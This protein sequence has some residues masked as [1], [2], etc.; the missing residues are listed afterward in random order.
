MVSQGDLYFVEDVTMLGGVLTTKS[1]EVLTPLPTPT[2]TPQLMLFPTEP[3]VEP[4]AIPTP[5]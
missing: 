3:E 2:P 5:K 4:S 1:G